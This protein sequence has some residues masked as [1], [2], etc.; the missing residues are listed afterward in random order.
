MDEYDEAV[1]RA[2]LAQQGRLYREPVAETEEEAEYFLED[3]C[4]VVCDDGKDAVRYMKENL[5]TE[6]MSDEEILN[7]E[8][9]F[10]VEDGRYLIVE[11]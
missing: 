8:E 3:A 2:F 9:V 7:C 1:I 4:A 5:D 10:P 6:G 11:G